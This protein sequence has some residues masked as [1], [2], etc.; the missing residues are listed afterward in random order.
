M[1]FRKQGPGGRTLEQADLE[2]EQ[3]DINQ[4]GGVACEHRDIGEPDVKGETEM[5]TQP[6]VITML[7]MFER[8]LQEQRTM[9]ELGAA[10]DRL[11][12]RNGQFDGRDVSHNMQD[13]K[14]EMVSC[15]VSEML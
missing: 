15:G 2:C 12:Q 11:I 14:A 5:A 8:M 4:L 1:P 3:H 6:E 10:I 7:M 9:T 13:Y